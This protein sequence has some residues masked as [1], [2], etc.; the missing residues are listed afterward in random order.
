MKHKRILDYV[1][2]VR[3][4]LGY[5]PRKTLARGVRKDPKCCPVSSSIPGR[6]HVGIC[7]IDFLDSDILY[8]VTPEHVGAFIREFDT[9]KYPEL[10]K[11]SKSKG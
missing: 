7:T 8:I 2:C 4:A 11:K 3:K 9:G 5:K 6:V 10:V 1:N